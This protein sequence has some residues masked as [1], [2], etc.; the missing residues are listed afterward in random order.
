[1]LGELSK[2]STGI[3]SLQSELAQV[4]D[5][6]QI[7]AVCREAGHRFRQRVLDPV[8]TI[9]LFVL[10]VLHGN[11]AIARLKDFTDKVFSEAAYC[12]V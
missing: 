5:A 9:H 3:S 1:M 10:Q 8:T 4:L 2:E 6:E 7:R 11:C 12:K